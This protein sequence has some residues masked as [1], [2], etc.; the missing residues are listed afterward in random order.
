MKTQPSWQTK[1][2]T[3]NIINAEKR[4]IRKRKKRPYLIVISSHVV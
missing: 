3:E 4:R 1:I 2:Y